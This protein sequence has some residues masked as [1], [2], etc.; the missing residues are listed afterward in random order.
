MKK[1]FILFFLFTILIF[2]LKAV[3]A[4][5]N[6][7][8][9]YLFWGQGCPHCEKEKLFLSKLKNKYPAIK[10]Y[11]FEINKNSENAKK[12]K[13]IGEKLQTDITGVPFMA[14]SDKNYF[15]GYYNDETTGKE[16]KKKNKL[17]FRK[18]LRR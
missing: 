11:D 15:L 9:L 4:E 13:K 14:I 7:V 5:E 2:P 17:L 18:L 1:I 10:L 8:N 12:L 6:S 16:I 3:L